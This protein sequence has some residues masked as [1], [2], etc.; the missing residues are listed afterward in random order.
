MC[1]GARYQSLYESSGYGSPEGLLMSPC[2]WQIQEYREKTVQCLLAGN[3]TKP[4]QYTI[5]TLLLYFMT[6]H[7]HHTDAQFG[8][9]I[10]MGLITRIAM[11]LGLHRDPSHMS[12]ISAFSGE[13][14]RRLWT[15]IVQTDLTTSCQMGLP[16]MVRESCYDTQE[17]SNYFDEDLDEDMM[18]LPEPRP[19]SC[20]TPILY[21]CARNK[22]L[23]VFSKI[24]DITTSVKPSSF[25]E[26]WELD[27]ELVQAR[28]AIPAGLQFNL[29]SPLL[30]NRQ[31]V[32]IYRI[33]LDTVFQNA[34]CI[35]HR[36]YLI[37]ARTNEQYTKSRVTCIEAALALL[38][39]QQT[40]D[41]ESKPGGQFEMHKSKIT[42]FWNHGML[43]AAAVLCV[44]LNRDLEDGLINEKYWEEGNR[45]EIFEA[46]RNAQR[47]LKKSWSV[48]AES[49]KGA[50]AIAVVLSKAG[51]CSDNEPNEYVLHGSQTQQFIV[52]QAP[53]WS[54][55]EFLGSGFPHF[56]D[57]V[58]V[59]GSYNGIV[60]LTI[61]QDKT[62]TFN[63]DIYTNFSG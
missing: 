59:E 46:L 33:Y 38:H 7:H 63:A 43:L 61:P 60:K 16:K 9:W 62:G 26:A 11:R 2:L 40:W 24:A 8:N 55:E 34:R 17:P 32:M 37:P 23:S 58:R 35:L 27:N 57:W 49:R 28:S 41:L 47:V 4:G 51:L 45:K 56:Q 12:K 10:L 3:Y 36:K 44:D 19:D 5:E 39:H 53:A 30:V 54:L 20:L 29:F 42:S 22:L 21:I 48:S 6:E 1:L 15:A 52:P 18:E 25:A 14:R 13:M 31:D 50:A